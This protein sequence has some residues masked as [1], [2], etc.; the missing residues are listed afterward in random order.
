MSE[1]NETANTSPT[2]EIKE[3]V[4]PK[5]RG[6]RGRVTPKKKS[7]GIKNGSSASSTQS[8]STETAKSKGFTPEKGEEDLVHVQVVRGDRFDKNTGEEISKPFMQ[9]YGKKEWMQIRQHS[10]SIGLSY[11]V[12]YEPK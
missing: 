7:T 3:V 2:V 1:D 10:A 4:T 5:S 9:K 12:I 6:T 8:S 11:E